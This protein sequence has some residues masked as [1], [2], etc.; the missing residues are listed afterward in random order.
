MQDQYLDPRALLGGLRRQVALIAV[1][2]VAALAVA[3]LVLVTQRPVY[4]AAALLLV[5]PSQKDLLSSE[6]QPGLDNSAGARVESEVRLVDTAPT[7]L[8]VARDLDLV[9]T[10]EFRPQLGTMDKL[11]LAM[12]LGQPALPSGQ[13]ALDAVMGKLGQAISASRVEGTFLIQV[14]AQTGDPQLSAKLA[15]AVAEGYIAEQRQVKVDA[16]LA[17]RQIIEARLGDANAAVVNAEQAVDDFIGSNL[18]K[19][20]QATGKTDIASI[21][22]QIQ[23]L[24]QEQTDLAAR[25]DS[26]SRGVALA[27]WQNVAASLQ[28]D[29]VTALEQQREAIERSLSGLKA[30]TSSATDLRKR[31]GQIEDQLKSN[32]EQSVVGL[33]DQIASNQSQ[34]A[35][36]KAQMRDLAI[37]SDMPP[38]MMTRLYELQQNSQIARSQLQALIA[39]EKDLET[40]AF[41]QVSDS[42]L[43]S[44]A[45]PPGQPSAPNPKLI[46]G[47]GLLAG[48]VLGIGAAL[49]RENFI[50]GF[51]SLGQVQAVLRL[52]SVVAVPWQRQPRDADLKQ[53]GV[54]DIMALAP[55]SVY[56]EAI[57]MVQVG[58]DQAERRLRRRAPPNASAGETPGLVV[59]VSSAMPAEGKTTVALSLARAFVASGRAT[60]LVDGDLRA[61][62]LH[63]QLQLEP[64]A[65][66][67][68]YLRDPNDEG[69]G[70]IVVNDPRTDLRVIIGARASDM[71]TD[72]LVSN[73]A[74]SALLRAAQHHFDIIIVDSPP[75]TRIVDALYLAEHADI[76]VFAVRW[77][78]T[79]QQA[80]RA[81]IALLRESLPAGADIVGVMNQ[82]RSSTKPTAYGQ[83]YD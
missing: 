14:A 39:R 38:E 3:V 1:V 78:R 54:A 4:T 71:P 20:S 73:E 21:R 16:V 80:A 50:G 58:V 82:Q 48:L 28:S 15:N 79:S 45:G 53:A 31:L 43:A 30:D 6:P 52:T 49:L 47:G 5:D 23:R 12:H 64:S 33:K 83:Q 68:D 75:I 66:L 60:L 70:K 25:A 27:D 24:Q 62:R 51:T 9:N 19:T 37:T 32:A 63:Q 29:A 67:I 34:A 36:L 44:P 76:A 59:L 55:L 13:E 17:S 40:Q 18:D 7:L 74:L 10:P 26:V 41:L 8:R 2:L 57:R 65:G 22:G 81:A 11:R 61:P 46:L 69:L 72:R 56:A 35:D 77:A 42:R